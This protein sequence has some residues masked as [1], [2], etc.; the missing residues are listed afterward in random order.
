VNHL[1]VEQVIRLHDLRSS[2][3]VLDRD[4]LDGAVHRSK[5]MEAYDADATVHDMAAALFAGVIQA[6]GFEK[7]NKRAAVLA[8]NAFYTL[9]GYRLNG[10][11]I[12]M[13]HIAVD[14]ATKTIDAKKLA[15]RL[16]LLTDELPEE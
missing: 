14:V 4:K 10:A 8:V 9:N 16:E 7:G 15:E 1:T 2:A 5:N 6:H 3:P 11:D 13:L 12:E